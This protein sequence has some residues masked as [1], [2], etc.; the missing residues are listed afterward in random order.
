MITPML[1]RIITGCAITLVIFLALFFLNI[2]FFSIFTGVI[3]LMA[4][5][6]YLSFSSQNSLFLKI[7]LL[8]LIV[9]FMLILGACFL[10]YEP[11][12]V[13]HIA[14]IK[15][16]LSLGALAWVFAI[17][18][19]LLPMKYSLFLKNK[20]YLNISSFIFLIPAWVAFISLFQAGRPFAIIYLILIT[21]LADTGA[22]FSGKFLGKHKMAPQISPQKTLEGALGGILLA[23]FVSAE[24]FELVGHRL[25]ADFL[26]ILLISVGLVFISIVGDLFESLLKRLHG[27]KDSGV[28][29]P[30]HGGA[31]DRIDSLIAVLPI[32]ALVESVGHFF[33]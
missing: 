8:A 11:H 5:W 17:F 16:V 13:H 30:G 1:K 7:I 22:Y 6:E 28:I 21:A 10:T 15:I 24:F 20:I 31:L 2:F 33:K 32:F 12:H 14:L 18:L 3:L 26:Q 29:L 19:V 4:A 23:S 25:S 27:V 9:L